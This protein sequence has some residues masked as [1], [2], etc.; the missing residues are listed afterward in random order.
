MRK[1]Q[2]WNT[3][4][5]HYKHDYCYCV[6]SIYDSRFDSGATV[7]YSTSHSYWTDNKTNTH[8][9]FVFK[10]TISTRQGSTNTSQK[11]GANKN[12][13]HFTP[14]VLPVVLCKTTLLSLRDVT[15][16]AKVR[17]KSILLTKH[18]VNMLLV[19][20]Q[21]FLFKW[22]RLGGVGVWQRSW[23]SVVRMI[24]LI[25][26]GP[27]ITWYAVTYCGNTESIPAM[28]TGNLMIYLYII[29]RLFVLKKQSGN[30]L[31]LQV[32][33]F[34]GLAV[35]PSANEKFDMLIPECFSLHAWISTDTEPQDALRCIERTVLM[36]MCQWGTELILAAQ[37]GRK[38]LYKNPS[39]YKIHPSLIFCNN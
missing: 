3:H 7:T 14:I 19:Q 22:D 24:A 32:F 27:L 20:A 12:N 38:A 2:F 16:G 33:F 35:V 1:P 15:V 39:N 4:T 8:W 31:K 23:G 21:G 18:Y 34:F 9:G 30:M 13:H 11:Q 25:T 17:T 6:W 28:F 5:A 37:K 26:A 10:V 36:W 29:H